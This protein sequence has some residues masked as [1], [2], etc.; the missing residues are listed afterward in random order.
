MGPPARRAASAAVSPARLS[1]CDDA[2][3]QPPLERLRRGQPLAE[4]RELHRARHAHARGNEQRRA[5]VGYQADV[6][7]REQEVGALG[8]D[9]QIAAERE[10]AAD[11]DGRPVYGGH[12]RLGHLAD[13][14]HDRVV[15][16]GQRPVD[17]RPAVGRD[18]PPLKSFRSAPEEKPR[19]APVITTAL[20]A[21]SRGDGRAAP[22]AGRR[23]TARSK[24]SWSRDG[25]ARS[26]RHHRER[27]R[28]TVCRSVVGS[29][30]ALLSSC[31][32]TAPAAGRRGRVRRS[33]AS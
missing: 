7:E 1:S 11:P 22:R 32:P 14:G 15:A 3:D 33:W 30:M 29:L 8:C 20:A 10:R 5:A 27:R 25:S 28:L 31:A 26:S 23:R 21:S 24:R 17:V 2:V 19:P 12:H 18:V 13:A 6:H 16:L 9:D 4:H